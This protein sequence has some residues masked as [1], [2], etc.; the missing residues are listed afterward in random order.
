LTA[1]FILSLDCEG[2]WGVADHL[3][4]NIHSCLSD[5]GLRSAY[6]KILALLDEYALPA[7]FA[8][9]GCFA[10]KKAALDSRIDWLRR[11]ELIAPNYIAP[12][13]KDLSEGSAQGWHGDWAVE[14][15]GEA[16]AAHEIALHGVTH[17]PWTELGQSG[18]E[19]EMAFLGEM[20]TPVRKARTFIYPRN[21]VA[22]RDVLAAAGIEAYRKAPPRRSRFAALLSEFDVFQEPEQDPM[23]D[24]ELV[25]IPGGQFV[26]WRSGARRLVPTR[27]SLERARKM[28]K[29]AEMTGG[30][31]HYWLHPENLAT[32]PSTF[33]LL[34]G[35]V[36]LAA[37]RRSAGGCTT[38]TQLQYA[39]SVR[40]RRGES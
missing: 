7:T 25:A 5:S 8:F 15:V 16:E 39:R 12:V 29:R 38:L 2:K 32:A 3:N 35:I 13:L 10:E 40:G 1:R 18:A 33:E 36:E 6:K 19:L 21:R 34:R 22:H 20:E 37:D 4:R 24:E 11:F 23:Q 30:V 14:A 28:M 17:V 27:V 26:N 9:V 31:I